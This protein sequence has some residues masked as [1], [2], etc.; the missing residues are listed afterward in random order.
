MCVIQRYTQYNCGCPI[1]EADQSLVKICAEKVRDAKAN[2]T[3][4]IIPAYDE[5]SPAPDSYMTEDDT[6]SSSDSGGSESTLCAGEE[7]EEEV[8]IET[9]STESNENFSKEDNDDNTLDDVVKQETEASCETTVVAKYEDGIK[10]DLDSMVPGPLRISSKKSSQDMLAI[11]G[12]DSDVDSPDGSK[13]NVDCNDNHDVDDQV[14]DIDNDNGS[15]EKDPNKNKNRKRWPSFSTIVASP[16]M[17]PDHEE[18][19]ETIANGYWRSEMVWLR[20][21]FRKRGKQDTEDLEFAQR[22][23]DRL[24]HLYLVWKFFNGGDPGGAIIATARDFRPLDK[25][26][27][28]ARHAESGNSRLR[29]IAEVD[30]NATIRAVAR[31]GDVTYRALNWALDDILTTLRDRLHPREMIA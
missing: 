11:S 18:K 14:V 7:E 8:D 5:N 12:C 3:V 26:N 4:Y 28:N 2:C 31:L 27:H 22:C 25:Y 10:V 9:E 16:R 24:W 30:S 20:P 13:S 29:D 17:C 21:K 23:A 1:P 15:T 19:F 6:D